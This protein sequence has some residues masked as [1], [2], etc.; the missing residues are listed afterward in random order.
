MNRSKLADLSEIFSS[1]AIVIT[2]IYL[3]IEITQNTDAIEGQTRQA[4]LTSAQAEITLLLD[5]PDLVR[6]LAGLEQLS[7]TDSIRLD[8]FLALALRSREFSWLQYQSGSIDEAQWATEE[9]VLISIFDSEIARLWW[10]RMGREVF[11]EEFVDF[12]D[13]LISGIPATNS[14]WR[15]S[16]TWAS[17]ALNESN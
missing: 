8:N 10:Q 7:E 12:V 5:N 13:E 9:V 16:A 4:V 15:T 17:T 1:I 2:L 6:S 11:G 3:A 14:I